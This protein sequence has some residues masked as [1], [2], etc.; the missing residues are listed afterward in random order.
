[1]E[2]HVIFVNLLSFHDVM[3]GLCDQLLSLGQIGMALLVNVNC[4]LLRQ[5]YNTRQH[6]PGDRSEDELIFQHSPPFLGRSPL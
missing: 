3:V 1:M 2:L 4:G 6:C 5:G